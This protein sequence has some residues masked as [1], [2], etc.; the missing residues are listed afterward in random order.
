MDGS[1][2]FVGYYARI[3]G[4]VGV[5]ASR[6]KLALAGNRDALTQVANLRD[7]TVGVSL[8][9]EMISLIKYQKSFEASAKFLS[10]V[11]EVMS[12]LLAIRG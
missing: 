6:N 10:T 12:Q 4:D 9:E 7:N 3:A 11:D 2:T 5:E 8:E 1:E